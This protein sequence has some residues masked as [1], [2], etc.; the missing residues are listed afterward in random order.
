M[1][2]PIVPM[3]PDLWP[4]VREIYCEVIATGNATLETEV[5][6]WEKWDGSHRK[7]CRLIALELRDEAV[8]EVLVPL[9]G[10]KVLGWAAL[11]PVS[12]RRVY[13]GVSEVS[14]FVAASARGRG[15]GSIVA[16]PGEGVGSERNL[17]SPGGDFSGK[18]SEYFIAQILR[19]SRGGCKAAY[20]QTRRCLERRD[21]DGASER[22]RR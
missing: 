12:S 19:I 1:D 9:E 10:A 3:P 11:S 8:A 21:L 16:R 4:A 2:Y 20:R 6:D 14:V 18:R 17:D 22:N 5:P 15:V 7:D 13:S